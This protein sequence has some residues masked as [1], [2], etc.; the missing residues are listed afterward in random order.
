[1]KRI[2]RVLPLLVL[3][4]TAAAN[5]QDSTSTA[6][7]V[8]ANAIRIYTESL[9]KGEVAQKEAAVEILRLFD[10]IVTAYPDSIPGQRIKANDQVGPIDMRALRTMSGVTAID[11]Q[12]AE[13]SASPIDPVLDPGTAEDKL[14][15]MEEEP[16]IPEWYQ[17]V[18]KDGTPDGGYGHGQFPSIGQRTHPGID[19]ISAC[20]LDVVAPW[21]GIVEHVVK[22]GDP[23]FPITGNAIILRHSLRGAPVVFSA[24]FNLGTTP[25]V[26]EG[27]VAMGEV[28]GTTGSL[29]DLESCGVHVE[30]RSFPAQE[31]MTFPLWNSLFGVGNWSADEDFVASWSDPEA[32]LERLNRIEHGAPGSPKLVFRD[33]W[34][35]VYGASKL[36]VFNEGKAYTAVSPSDQSLLLSS[37]VVPNRVVGGVRFDLTKLSGKVNFKNTNDV[38]MHLMGGEFLFQSSVFN[39][40]N[41]EIP[42]KSKQSNKVDVT[43]SNGTIRA[44][45]ALFTP[46]TIFLGNEDLREGD[47]VRFELVASNGSLYSLGYEIPLIA[48]DVDAEFNQSIIYQA[49]LFVNALKNC[50]VW[51]QSDGETITLV[52]ST[53]PKGHFQIG[54]YA[55]FEYQN[56]TYLKAST[57][58]S[59]ANETIRK[60]CPALATG[61]FPKDGAFELV[62]GRAVQ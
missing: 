20:G 10:L 25:A 49:K 58:N 62:L 34:I 35:A 57:I 37:E 53:D 59:V 26:V 7:A 23:S 48:P 18:L 27:E 47:V 31:R 51:S 33:D 24:Y 46:A 12:E 19:L 54:K 36:S 4:T 40:K 55:L 28:I 43:I 5:G 60:A 52:L 41:L 45:G 14:T 2:L 3:L 21:D 56:I 9:N 16:V 29:H 30:I 1:M 17:R 22:A 50:M 44:N 8:F 11:K 6:N 61:Q 15:S 39:S 42:I 13:A 32:W 38:S